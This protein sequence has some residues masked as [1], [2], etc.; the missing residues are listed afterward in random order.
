M[1]VSSVVLNPYSV[2]LK[3]ISS[4]VSTERTQLRNTHILQSIVY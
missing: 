2:V 1:N 4:S 3:M